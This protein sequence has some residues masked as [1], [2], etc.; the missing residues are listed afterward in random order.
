MKFRNLRPPQTLL[1]LSLASALGTLLL[2]A[3]A[4]AVTAAEA[5]GTIRMFSVG[6]GQ[7]VDPAGSGSTH[8]LIVRGTNEVF[9]VQQKQERLGTITTNPSNPQGQVSFRQMPKGSEPHGIT[10]FNDQPW[11]LLEGT[12][13]VV[14]LGRQRAQGFGTGIKLKPNL[15]HN[16]GAEAGPHGVTSSGGLL[17]YAGKEGSVFGWIEPRTR[18]QGSVAAPLVAAGGSSGG[19]SAKPIWVAPEKNGGVW[20]TELIS[21]K[22]CRVTVSKA[23]VTTIKEWLLGDDG[24]TDY[25]IGIVDDGAGGAWFTAEGEPGD[26]TASGYFGH[27][28]ASGEIYTWSVPTRFGRLGGLSLDKA[29]NLWTE[30]TTSLQ[31]SPTATIAKVVTSRLPRPSG[32]AA[33]KTAAGYRLNILNPGSAV[34]EIRVPQAAGINHFLHRIVVDGSDKRVWFSDIWGDQIGVYYVP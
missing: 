26:P 24:V 25:P 4:G 7:G 29:G 16:P 22:I 6:K 28:T 5:P 17:W 14:P 27:L 34:T 2:V 20:G 23:G 1:T 30:Y 9:F 11:V 15:S 10:F 3:N 21:S 32:S 31:A 18:R 19:D 13:E 12:S 8:E 33:V